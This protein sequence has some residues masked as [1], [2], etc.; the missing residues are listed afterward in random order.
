MPLFQLLRYGPTEYKHGL[1]RC[2]E[3]LVEAELTVLEVID[4]LVG[5]VAVINGFDKVNAGG[6]EL[7]AELNG[8][9]VVAIEA[10]LEEGKG[11]LNIGGLLL[12]E[13]TAG[14][15]GGCVEA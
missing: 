14:M 7:M 1:C 2:G 5:E 10:E 9:G 13:A 12:E 3:F 8:D 4:S 15:E 11:A 6:I